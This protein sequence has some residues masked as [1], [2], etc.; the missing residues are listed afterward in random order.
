ML[1]GYDRS[2]YDLVA[3]V[4]PCGNDYITR[5]RKDRAA[6]LAQNLRMN[7][8]GGGGG[9]GGG[10]ECEDSDSKCGLWASDGW[11]DRCSAFMHENCKKSCE[12]CDEDGGGGGDCEDNHA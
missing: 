11:C 5:C 12:L 4:F 1:R 2:L 7:C 6:E 10:E 9:G 3:E 8:A